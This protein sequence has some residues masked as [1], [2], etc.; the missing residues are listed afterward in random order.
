MDVGQLEARIAELE[1][2]IRE[3]VPALR[4][5]ADDQTHGCTHGCTGAC[6]EGTSG[7]TYDCTH[8]CTHGCTAAS[9]IPR[10][11]ERKQ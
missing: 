11:E 1:I 3:F 9:C 10:V 7:C 5:A 8:G 2:K 4:V 6:P